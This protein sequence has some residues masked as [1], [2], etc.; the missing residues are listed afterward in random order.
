M[1]RLAVLAALTSIPTLAA[2][3]PPRPV[4]PD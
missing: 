3:K 2:G 4:P 1:T